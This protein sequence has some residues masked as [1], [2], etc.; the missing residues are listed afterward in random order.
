MFDVRKVQP[1]QVTI[2]RAASG[3]EL[4]N[5]EKNK[6]AS[7]EEN[8]QENKIE[9]ISIN[10]ERQY[11]DPISKEVKISLGEL[12]AKDR[13]TPEELSMD[14]LFFIKCEFDENF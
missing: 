6:L 2:I 13:I 5:Y 9:S 14:D 10:N 12:A 11:L 4:S 7:I 8:A 1:Q 3:Y